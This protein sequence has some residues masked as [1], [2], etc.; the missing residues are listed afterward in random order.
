MEKLVD[1]M[2]GEKYS[3]LLI[4]D[5]VSPGQIEIVK[6][7]YENLYSQLSGFAQADLNFGENESSSVSDSLTKGFSKSISESISDSLTF[8]KGSSET[9]TKTISDTKSAG[10]SVGIETEK[11]PLI[12]GLLSKFGIKNMGFNSS[13][14]HT[15][16]TSEAKGTN[17]GISI[18]E[19]KTIG[20]VK[21]VLEQL[22]QS[23]TETKG[24]S[25]SIQI[26]QENK[27]IKDL[28]EKIDMQL[29]R[30]EVSKDT[31]MWNCS[32]YCLADIASVC[33]IT[34]S[35]YQSLLRGENS[36]I[37]TGVITEWH[38]EQASAI[39]PYI[40]KMNH[41]KL[42]LSE[43]TEITPTSFISSAELTIHAGIPQT[44]VSGLPVL[45]MASFGREVSAH[46]QSELSTDNKFRYKSWQYLSHG[47]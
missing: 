8:T 34:A 6:Q 15:E 2:Q 42:C 9:T 16:T 7:G 40:K 28:L 38:K 37:E 10:S 20:D 18:G 31:G 26:K 11:I 12:G 22:S 46:W 19:V 21:T 27:T 44:S 3:L 29:K 45:E 4:A 1:S 24:K 32:V 5:P 23:I 17:K 25:R 33:K 47:K 30:I 14:S 39:L 35:A 43:N 41:P 13:L 36:S